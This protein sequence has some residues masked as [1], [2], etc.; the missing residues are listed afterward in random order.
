MNAGDRHVCRDGRVARAAGCSTAPH[1]RSAG[2]QE[3]GGGF[4][5]H[6]RHADVWARC[7]PASPTDGPFGGGQGEEMFRSLMIDEYG[8]QIEAQGGLR[9]VRFRAARAAEDAGERTLSGD[10]E[11]I[12]RL[13]K[14]AERLMEAIEADIAA[15]KAGKPQAMRTI[16][17]EMQ[18]LTALYGREAQGFTQDVGQESAVAAAQP[19]LRNDKPVPRS[20]QSSRAHD[21]A[22]AQRQRRHDQ[23]DCRRS[24][25]P[26]CA[27]AHLFA[28][29]R[30]RPH[31]PR[32]R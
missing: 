14:M 13:V 19:L 9:P 4:R 1:Q 17:P 32:R 7:S 20:S 30:L 27:D 3:N 2:R 29:R 18:R 5:R 6:V 12:E 10:S 26:G 28:A 25:S 23:G 22:R 21:H 8:K 15:L 31:V 16:E 24:R 11:R